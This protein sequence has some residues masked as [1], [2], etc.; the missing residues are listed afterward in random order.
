MKL[1]VLGCGDAFA[2]L[3][4]FNTSFL[5][6]GENKNVLV[7]CGASTLVQMEKEGVTPL[8]V[9]VIV[10]THFHGDHYGGIPFQMISN[11][12]VYNRTKPLTIWGPS[13]VKKR[14]MDLQEAM[15]A[16]TSGIFDE[17]K[18]TFKEY[19]ADAWIGFDDIEV[20]SKEVV[21][22]PPSNPH[23][24]KIKLDDHV[25]AFSGDTEWTENLID[26]ADGSDLF[27][28]ECNNLN[29]DSP[30]HLS[31][32]TILE[33]KSIMNTARLMINHMGAEVIGAESLEI[34]R[35]EDGMVVEF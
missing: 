4:R 3:G 15:Y 33:K 32:K 1:K 6:Y 35:L 24:V 19:V 13:G 28:C 31:Y 7:D 20:F 10:I 23:G 5:L 8:D 9:D 30:G 16:G 26:L 21:H 27:V 14:V 17:L 2:S 18:V 34:E 25:F 22:S 12:M 29:Q 11:K